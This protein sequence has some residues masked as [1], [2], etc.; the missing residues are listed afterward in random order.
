MGVSLDEKVEKAVG[1]LRLFAPVDGSP[2]WGAFS[3]GK[4]S[5]VIKEVARL[6]G[7]PVVWHYNVTTVDPP[8]LVRFIR[9]EHPDVI[10]DRPARPMWARIAEKGIPPTRIVRWCCE[11]YK[12]SAAEGRVIVGVR[13]AESVKRKSR[14]AVVTRMRRNGKDQ[15]LIAPIVW[16]SDAD[17]WSFIRGRGLPYCELYDEVDERGKKK[18][19]RLGCVLCPMGRRRVDGDSPRELVRW[20]EIARL[21]KKGIV[22][23]WE[24]RNSEDGLSRRLEQGSEKWKTPEEMWLWWLRHSDHNKGEGCDGLGL[25]V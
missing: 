14:A 21:W 19:K 24:K 1:T 7:V 25:F 22:R 2:Y 18:W 11:E 23:A 5:C 8:E 10:F 16:W 13:A 15:E 3:G 20:P 4:D 9:R 17:V 12:E 6:A